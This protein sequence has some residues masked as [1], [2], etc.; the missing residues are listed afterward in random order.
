M[1][2]SELKEK[3]EKLDKAIKS[4]TT[5]ASF[6]PNLKSKKEGFEN[7]LKNLSKSEAPK[8]TAEFPA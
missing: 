8:P 3:I 2:Q 7:D 5:P 1:T 4:P 6:L